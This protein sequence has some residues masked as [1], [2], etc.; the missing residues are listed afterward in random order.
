MDE[1][2]NFKATRIEVAIE[3]AVGGGEFVHAVVR[4]GNTAEGSI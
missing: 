1:L 3:A 2:L 4:V